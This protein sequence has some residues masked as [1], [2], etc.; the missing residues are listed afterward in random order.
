[1]Q[2]DTSPRKVALITGA[3]RRIGATIARTLHGAGYDLA[4]H[5]LSSENDMQA[6]RLELL[7]ARAD[8]V[9]TLQADLADTAV[10]P[11]S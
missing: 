3:A 8:S 6:L 1:M 4:L 7:S 11:K 10:L 2:T 5:Y 9:I